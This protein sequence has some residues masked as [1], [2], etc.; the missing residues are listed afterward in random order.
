MVTVDF[1]ELEDAVLIMSRS[2]DFAEAWVS[3]DTG[4][5]HV[6]FSDIS[7][8]DAEPLPDD[9]DV[10]DRFIA[11]PDSHSLDLGQAVVFGF[12]EAEMPDE[13]E[14]VRQMFRRQGAYR[15]FGNLVDDRG[16]R[17]RW[18]AFRQGRTVAALREWCEE[19]GLQLH[20]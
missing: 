3:L 14:R 1:N 16:L 8:N 17:D 4:A 6:R 2:D 13:Y 11:V 5:V 15:H 20:V 19:N 9:I 7:L 12:V 10:S 18:H